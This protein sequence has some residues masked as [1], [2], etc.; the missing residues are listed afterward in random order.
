VAQQPPPRPSPRTGR[1]KSRPAIEVVLVADGGTLTLEEAFPKHELA[2]LMP[3]V[4]ALVAQAT[5]TALR[6]A[7]AGA[8]QGE[9]DRDAGAGI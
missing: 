3:R 8:P 5:G 9:R 4:R 7:P 2:R 1:E 6:D